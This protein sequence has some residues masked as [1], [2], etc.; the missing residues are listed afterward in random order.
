MSGI[1]VW[2]PLRSRL[3]HVLVDG[4]ST[5][6][7]EHAAQVAE[8]AGI[9]DEAFSARG[10]VITMVGGSAIEIHAP[11]IYMSGDIDVV[12]ESTRAATADRAK[13]FAALGLERVGRHWRHGDLFIEVVPGPVSGPVEE[14]DV[15]GA[16]FRVVRKEVPLRDRVVGFKHWRH[17]AYG[18]QAIAML[19]AFGEELDM[20]WLDSELGREDARDALEALQ[21]LARSDAPVT[22]ERLLAL[23]DALEERGREAA[24][25]PPEEPNQPAP[26]EEP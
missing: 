26:N 7:V 9:L 17:T 10:L 21:R 8:I 13:V 23:I 20:Q 16:A 24:V 1:D 15:A 3:R 14:V 11:G 19:I 22:H 4:F 2:S 12:V 18:D 25:L 6:P 5:D